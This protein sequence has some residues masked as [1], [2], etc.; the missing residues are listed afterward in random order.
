MEIEEDPDQL[1]A[2]QPLPMRQ[3]VPVLQ[4]LLQRMAETPRTESLALSSH[5][6]TQPQ[7]TRK[8]KP[9]H[10]RQNTSLGNDSD[11]EEA[12]EESAMEWQRDQDAEYVPSAESEAESE[13]SDTGE[14]SASEAEEVD[15]EERDS[16][17]DADT[18]AGDMSDDDD[19]QVAGNGSGSRT[20]EIKA[21]KPLTKEDVFGNLSDAVRL[22]KMARNEGSK[23]ARFRR[24]HGYDADDVMVL[25]KIAKRDRK[26]NS[27]QA[28]ALQLKRDRATAKV[29]QETQSQTSSLL[30]SAYWSTVRGQLVSRFEG[31]D[32]I[33]FAAVALLARSFPLLSS[34]SLY[35]PLDAA[36]PMIWLADRVIEPGQTVE[37]LQATSAEH[38]HVRQAH[39]IGA[40]S[41]DSK[42]L[43]A[44]IAAARQAGKNS[45]VLSITHQLC[46]YRRKS[47]SSEFDCVLQ[48]GLHANVLL[49]HLDTL[50]VEIL[51]PHGFLAW[52]P[53]QKN[54][55]ELAQYRWD[56]IGRV[57]LDRIASVGGLDRQSL[58]FVYPPIAEG[59]QVKETRSDYCV[60][61]CLYCG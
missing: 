12:F 43:A 25:E 11:E 36:I 44:T 8:R 41:T 50:T 46:K 39:V 31:F 49:L 60:F 14:E 5:L 13:S 30:P 53:E 33:T 22:L 27:K 47:S 23:L 56:E 2:T 32:E 34:A 51:E 35:L 17:A 52:I 37:Q 45:V 28:K 61:M 7:R 19:T 20:M 29:V 21:E 42:Q 15:E 54:A 40:K 16:L 58:R 3:Q 26:E 4:Y 1:L 57:L 9:S 24:R 18:G 38:K 10:A 48:E 55:T 59:P 6:P